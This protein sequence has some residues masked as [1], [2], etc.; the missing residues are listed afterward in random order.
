VQETFFYG[1]ECKIWADFGSVGNAEKKFWADYEQLL[2]EV[3]LCFQ[4]QIFL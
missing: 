3:F 4:G 2:R 1:T